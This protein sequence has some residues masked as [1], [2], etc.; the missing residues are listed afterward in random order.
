MN[1]TSIKLHSL[2]AQQGL[3]IVELMVA[4]VLSLVVMAVTTSIYVSNKQTYR[5]LDQ[6]SLLQENGRFAIFFLREHVLQ[7]GFPRE[8]LDPF[9]PVTPAS[10]NTVRVQFRSAVDC[11]NAAATGGIADNTFTISANQL[12]CN[13]TVLVDG[14][15]TMQIVYGVDIDD[16]GIANTYATSAQVDTGAFGAVTASW[17]EVVSVRIALLA[18]GEPNSL[19]IAPAVGVT[20]SLA[21]FPYTAAADRTPRR[22]FTTT[23]PLR[24]RNKTII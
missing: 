8:V 6:Y 15:E 14:I 13:G 1:N 22:V 24:N 20:Y 2:K 19:D 4:L 10:N 17:S 23:I 5:F 18:V 11:D 3:S 21:G 12:T 16:D 7:A 9:L